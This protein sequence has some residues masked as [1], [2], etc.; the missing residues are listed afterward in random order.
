[1]RRLYGRESL[2]YELILNRQ[3]NL[4]K[5]WDPWN[6]K[7]DNLKFFHIIGHTQL[8]TFSEIGFDVGNYL[9]GFSRMDFY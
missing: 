7:S 9:E 4:I 3:I 8:H 6:C 2:W 1:M 5:K